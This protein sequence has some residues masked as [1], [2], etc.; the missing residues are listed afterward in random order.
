MTL[1]C[2]MHFSEEGSAR[3]L[4]E[5]YVLCEVFFVLKKLKGFSIFVLKILE[6]NLHQ[7]P[8]A[9]PVYLGFLY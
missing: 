2:H 4:S 3:F 1:Q 5:N 9:S 8:A 6:G 7:Q